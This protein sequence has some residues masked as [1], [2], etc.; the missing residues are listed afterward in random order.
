M[1]TRPDPTYRPPIDRKQTEQEKRNEDEL[2]EDHP[3]NSATAGV[4]GSHSVFTREAKF[5]D[6]PSSAQDSTVTPSPTK[7]I[8]KWGDKAMFA[9]EPIDGGASGPKVYLLWMTPDPL[10]AIAAMCKMYKGEVCR[11]MSTITDAERLEYFEQ[12][13]ATKLQAPFEAVQFHFLIEGVTRAFTH[14]MVRQRTAVYAQESM[15]F[16]VKDGAHLDEAVGLPPSLAG[17]VAHPGGSAY[18]GNHPYFDDSLAQQQ[19]RIWDHAISTVGNSYDLL[20]NSGVPAEDA[21]GLLPTNSLTRIEYNTNLRNLQEHAG[22]RLCTQAQFEWRLVWS[23]MVKAIRGATVLA[24]GAVHLDG[25]P[26]NVVAPVYMRDKLAELFQPACYLT[27]KCEFKANFDRSCKIRDRVD[28]FEANGIP[29]NGWH[30]SGWVDASRR[31]LLPIQ[32]AEWLLDPTA[33]R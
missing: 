21:R 32:P 31:P 13:Q 25:K 6:A 16:A 18:D 1:T 7:V 9:A 5:T 11:D 29:S 24:P 10:G 8:Q 14:Q 15:R 12:I 2:R 17:T 4:Q 27:G 22:N 30:S 33:A 3:S 28:A 23:Q 26:L 19:R 20:V